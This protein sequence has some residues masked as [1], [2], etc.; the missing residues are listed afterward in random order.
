MSPRS[1]SR[2]VARL[3][4][5]KASR[6]M[7]S[8]STLPRD[9]RTR[10]GLLEVEAG[11]RRQDVDASGCDTHLKDHAGAGEVGLR[12][13]IHRRAEGSESPNHA[14]RILRRRVDPDVQV[15]G[16]PRPAVQSQ[17]V[18]ADDQEADVMVDERS[19]Q[20]DKVLVHRGTRPATATGPH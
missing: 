4:L 8:A 20:I 15:A 9:S 16:G 13:L 19:Q 10:P 6:P 3:F 7:K 12:D 18:G 1:F 2:P 11:Q 14:N 17:R 5:M